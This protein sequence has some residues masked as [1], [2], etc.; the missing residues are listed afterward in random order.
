MSCCS[1]LER[2]QLKEDDDFISFLSCTVRNST[3]VKVFFFLQS[4]QMHPLMAK[5]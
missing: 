2:E 5:G 1:K 4:T 3:A